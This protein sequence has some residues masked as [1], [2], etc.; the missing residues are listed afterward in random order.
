M[1]RFICLSKEDAQKAIEGYRKRWF[2]KRKT[3]FTLIKEEA[4]QQESA[5]VDNAAANNAAD[6]DAALQEL[7][8]DVCSFGYLTT[9]ITV[10]H[11]DLEIA[12][13]NV[14]RVKQVIQSMGFVVRD[15][16]LG[17]Q[18]AWLG[19]LPGHVYGNVRRPIVSSV[20]LAHMM[21]LSSVWA[22]DDENSHL[23]E[24]SGIGHAHIYCS[25]TGSTPF[26]L[27]LAVGDVGHTLVI[28]PT[29]PDWN[30]RLCQYSPSPKS[31]QICSH[32]LCP[33]HPRL[34][35]HNRWHKRHFYNGK[36]QLENRYSTSAMRPRYS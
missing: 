31:S 5:F 14:Q 6:A 10:W 23:R 30:T 15:E 29:L 1:T 27:H 13:R 20:N 19:S 17:G 35:F 34:S 22:G 3:L 18:D 25:T 26:R 32:L 9:T 36:H 8:A 12:R 4:A 28:G 24:V 21:P 16:T 11:E 33:L 2:Q 7:G